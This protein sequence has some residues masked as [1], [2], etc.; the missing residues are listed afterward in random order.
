[1]PIDRLLD[2]ALQRVPINHS[3]GPAYQQAARN[4]QG[5]PGI[6]RAANGRLWATWYTGGRTEDPNNHVVLVT[7]EDGGDSWSEPVLVIDPPAADVRTSDPVLWHDPQGRLWLFWMQ[8]N[9][10]AQTFD[11]RGGVWA[12]RT[13]DATVAKPSWTEPRRIANGIMMNKPTVLASGDWL[14]PAAIWSHAEYRLSLPDEAYP[15]V[16]RSQDNGDTFECIG[17]AE[18]PLRGPDEHMIVERRDGTLWMLVRR[19]DGIGE[20]ISTDGGHTWQSSPE[21][22]L[23]GPNSR[24]HIRRL[25]SGR[26]LLINHH[27]FTGRS[28]LT[29][30]LSDDDGLTW[31]HHL[32]LD[33][34]DQVSYPDA[35]E[36]PAGELHVIYDRRRTGEGDILLQRLT[37]QD[38]L[39][40]A[41][42]GHESGRLRVISTLHRDAIGTRREL[43]VDD[44]L[45]DQ[46]QGV[47][48]Q[49][50]RPVP[51]EIALSADRPW[52]GVLSGYGTVLRDGETLRLYYKGAPN[53]QDPE[54][55]EPIIRICL[56]ESRDGI[57]WQRPELDVE[58]FQGQKTNVVFHGF[59]DDKKGVH[60]FTPFIDANPDCP[61]D[62]RYKAVGGC[63]YATKGNLYAMV[64]ADGIH[65]SRFGEE[66]VLRNPD[67]GKFDSQNLAFWDTERSEYRI[68]FRDKPSKEHMRI[69]RTAT[70]RDFMHWENITELSYP[71]MTEME[72]Y[73]SQVQPYPRAPHL[74]VGFP[75]RYVERPWSPAVEAL[76]E[77]AHRRQRAERHERFGTALSDGLFMSSRD[78]QQFHRWDDAFLRPGAQ[79]EGNWTYGDNFQM[80]GLFETPS[81]LEG[82]PAELSFLSTEHYWR[83]PG[84]RFRRF[85]LRQ[86]GFVSVNAPVSG[87]H[88]SLKPLTFGGRTLQ[89]N[90]STSAAGSVRVQIEDFCGRPF[91]GFALAD[92][93]PVIGDEL[94]R[95]VSWQGGPD[96]SSLAGEL[97]RLRFELYDA[98]LYSFRFAE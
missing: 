72:L 13:D 16:I 88:L 42:P 22:V 43:F 79:L 48:L 21:V 81:A 84:T 11:G 56:A 64:S 15:N 3:P 41:N 85:S 97:V 77:L 66:P 55:S 25:Q 19:Q 80:L 82:A 6:E 37:E 30:F 50:H 59:D 24:F 44:H 94:E 70:S 87:G 29:A 92:C 12:I 20:A 49:L 47:S 75:S 62:Q 71:G 5:I 68:Y 27:E 9:H 26:L 89:L 74:F 78:G 67:H 86:D 1:M 39:K 14:L 57:H 34:R 76:P 40:G 31:P 61:P 93:V 51:R 98:D 7:S 65:W 46:Q 8:T 32:L 60:G 2:L 83:K 73:T 35:V 91:P 36:G 53:L 54:E 45:I 63:R 10:C 58:E 28:H 38:I 33:E 90:V 23:P 18:V 17:H 69:I 4:W 95:Q 52:E 96:V